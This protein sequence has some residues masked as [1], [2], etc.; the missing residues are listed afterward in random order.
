MQANAVRNLAIVAGAGWTLAAALALTGFKSLLPE[1]IYPSALVVAALACAAA[2]M[3]ALAAGRRA[4][5]AAQAGAY[6]EVRSLVDGVAQATAER[7]E[8]ACEELAAVDDLLA[9]AIEQ[10]ATAFDVMTRHLEACAPASEQAVIGAVRDAVTALQFR[11]VAGQKLEHVR[12]ELEALEAAMQRMRDL[13]GSYAEL[14]PGRAPVYAGALGQF[15]AGVHELLRELEQ[16]K[17]AS[18][19]RQALMHAGDVELF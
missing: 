17:G 3:L 13:D 1:P 8:T 12:K 16:A 2:W 4:A 9:H 14:A 6:A 15:A 11:D 5:Y 19:A 7:I 18:P 10:L